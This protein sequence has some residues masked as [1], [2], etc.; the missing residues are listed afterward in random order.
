MLRQKKTNLEIDSARLLSE[1]EALA[2]ISEAEPP[3]VTR[4]LFTPTDMRAR[5]WLIANRSPWRRR[6]GSSAAIDGSPRNSC[7]RQS[8]HFRYAGGRLTYSLQM[9]LLFAA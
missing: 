9:P 4:I 3:A 2:L 8:N 1:I 6:L 5:A 7:G